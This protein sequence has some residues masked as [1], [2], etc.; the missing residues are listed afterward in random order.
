MTERADDDVNVADLD[1]QTFVQFAEERAAELEPGL[2]VEAMRFVL[3]LT[4]AASTVV[5]DLE[6]SVHRPAGWSWAGFRLVFVLWMAGPLEARIA[7]KLSGNSR[8]A[9]STLANTLERRGIL[10]RLPDPADGRS[11]LFRL[12][13]AGIEAI[14][15]VYADHNRR[16]QLWAS[17]LTAEERE[18]ATRIV[19]KLL[20]AAPGLD[21]RRRHD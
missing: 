20:T 13:E 21:V 3:T 12:T 9:T 17:V 15:G 11:V 7:A 2:D 6:S 14:Q 4:R 1:F 16:E 19:A 10:E 8:Q 18:A 5:Y